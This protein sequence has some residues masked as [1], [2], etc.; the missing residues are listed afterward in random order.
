MPWKIGMKCIV[1]A[2]LF[3]LVLI[4]Q[5]NAQP[6]PASAQALPKNPQ[7]DIAYVPPKTA[8][9]QPIHDRVKRLQVLETLQEFLSPLRL[10]RKL[11]V[12][13][14]E[15]GTPQIPYQSDQV[16]I[17]YEYLHLIEGNAP[18]GRK[19]ARRAEQNPLT[20]EAA[21]VG[22][23]V[24]MAIHETAYA[25]FDILDIPLW[26]RKEDAADNVAG[27]IMLELGD[28]VAAI[29]L[30]G[31]SWFLQRRG[32]AGPGD[33]AEVLRVLEAQR[34]YNY[35]CMAYG[36]RADKFG[37]LVENGILPKKRAKGCARDYR[38]IRLGFRKLILPHVDRD[39][40]QQVRDFKWAS[41]L[42]LGRD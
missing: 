20:K 18:V 7:V 36:A 19:P 2:I 41:R 34:Y 8:S 16:T 38:R 31:T 32:F 1:G 30:N 35:L 10:P 39:L 21:I 17:C 22:A 6:A 15:C 24:H 29:T 13:I 33:A 3:T 4:G 42:T 14:A 40:L 9:F 26:G 12:K 28:D 11:S 27:F 5:A 37:S 23:F 25:V